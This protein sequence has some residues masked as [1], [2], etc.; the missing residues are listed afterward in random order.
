MAQILKI[1]SSEVKIGTNDGKVI[2][3]PISSIAY[4][5]PRENDT[6][7]VY[8]DGKNYIIK[9]ANPTSGIYQ[10]DGGGGKKINKH[11]F[12]W[13]GTFLFGGLGVD[14]FLRGQIGV[15]ICKLL[16]SWLTLGIWELV[17]WIIALTKA[18]GSA[19]GS[20]EEI[21]FDAAGNYTK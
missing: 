16:F 18:Y 4:P 10:E 21:T 8:Q 19:Y 15:G 13:V 1:D 7:N 11:L 9:K 12:V 14:R 20:V 5:D 6:V 2:T 17:D 3:V